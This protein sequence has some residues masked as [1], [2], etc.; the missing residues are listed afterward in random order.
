[1]RNLQTFRNAEEA[2]PLCN[3]IDDDTLLHYQNGI[4]SSFDSFHFS[5][6]PYA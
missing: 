1:M 4:L 3:G 5:I 6:F 2:I